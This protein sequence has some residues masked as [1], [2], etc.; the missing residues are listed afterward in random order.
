MQTI[1]SKLA[2][3][4]F[5]EKSVPGLI[6]L[7]GVFAYGLLIPLLGFYQDDW[8]HIF[9]ISTQGVNSLWDLFLYDNRPFAAWPYQILHLL[10]GLNPVAWQTSTLILHLVSAVMLWL[11][12]KTLWPNQVRQNAW[13]IALFTVYPFFNLQPLSV[14]YTVHW[15][16]YLLYCTSLYL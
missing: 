9:H 16:A 5:T 14:A 2:K 13:V 6:L 4:I 7:L 15:T 3:I 1:R 12:I 8:H 10:L 11:V